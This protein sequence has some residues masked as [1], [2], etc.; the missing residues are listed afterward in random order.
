MEQQPHAGVLAGSE[1][2]E[3]QVEAAPSLQPLAAAGAAPAVRRRAVKPLDLWAWQR[4][5]ALPAAC[6]LPGC[7]NP[8]GL[9]PGDATR[10]QQ[11]TACYSRSQGVCM[12]HLRAQELLLEGYRL[13]YCQA[14]ACLILVHTPASLDFG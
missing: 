12:E 2:W 14:R 11:R 10:P 5:Q 7:H 8:L 6:R 9:P 1:S 13:R 3:A 4:G